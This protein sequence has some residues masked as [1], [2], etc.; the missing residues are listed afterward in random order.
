MKKASSQRQA[1]T[2]THSPNTRLGTSRDRKSKP[3]GK[4][5]SKKPSQIEVSPE[6]ENITTNDSFTK[7]P[8]QLYVWGCKSRV[9][10]LLLK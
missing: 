4:L 10:S 5:Q 7:Q 2:A 1:K 9:Q 3:V 8:S 6:K